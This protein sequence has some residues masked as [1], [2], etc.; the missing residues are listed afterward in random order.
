MPYMYD[1]NKKRQTHTQLHNAEQHH[2][3]QNNSTEIS[4]HWISTFHLRHI[5]INGN[6]PLVLIM[7]C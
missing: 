6:N 7:I 2:A 4:C 3:I 5:C 1:S